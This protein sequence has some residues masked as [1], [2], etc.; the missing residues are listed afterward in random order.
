M[1]LID[2]SIFTITF[3][4][5]ILYI[6][7]NNSNFITY[8]TFDL[9]CLDLLNNY[10]N[11]NPEL[12][13]DNEKIKDSENRF[14]V[15]YPNKK[16]KLLGL[17]KDEKYVLEQII[18]PFISHKT[19]SFSLKYYDIVPV[20]TVYSKK[21]A[22]DID[23]SLN[24]KQVINLLKVFSEFKSVET[25]IFTDD[26]DGK[27]ITIVHFEGVQNFYVNSKRP[28]YYY[29]GFRR[30]TLNPECGEELDEPVLTLVKKI[31]EKENGITR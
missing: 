9:L 24:N 30:L 1:D 12:S 8:P 14:S 7:A 18:I 23:L 28:F 21:V 20:D 17:G 19:E 22:I 29:E 3:D 15:I 27:K 13:F 5:N 25:E 10:E 6:M 31:K 11:I 4:K 16:I 26:G 2:M